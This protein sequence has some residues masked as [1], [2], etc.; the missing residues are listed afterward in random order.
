MVGDGSYSVR[1]YL[2]DPSKVFVHTLFVEYIKIDPSS[3]DTDVR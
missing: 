3:Q 2:E 1:S